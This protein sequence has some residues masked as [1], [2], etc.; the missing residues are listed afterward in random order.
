MAI[1]AAM[2]DVRDGRTLPVP[3]HLKDTH[4]K[5]SARLGHGAEYK[6][7]H[8][9]AGGYV[10]QDYLGVDK[11][12]YDPTDR[13]YEKNIRDMLSKQKRRGE[14]ADGANRTEGETS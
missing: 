13:G 7:A 9:Y 4:Y 3:K 12:Y 1:S 5:G 14:S 6:Y 10:D 2:K 11:T 8:D